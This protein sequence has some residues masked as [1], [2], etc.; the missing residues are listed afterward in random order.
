MIVK[1]KIEKAQ[2]CVRIPKSLNKRLEE[3]ISKIGISKQA[4]ILRLVYEELERLSSTKRK[5]NN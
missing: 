1:T 2:I 3:H 5:E 4:F